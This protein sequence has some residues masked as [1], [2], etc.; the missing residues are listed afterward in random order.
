MDVV[1]KISKVRTGSAMG[2]EDVPVKPILI[3]SI[4]LLPEKK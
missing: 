2:H 3:E 1:N 4:K